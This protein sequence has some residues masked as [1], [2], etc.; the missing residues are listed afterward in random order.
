LKITQVLG[1]CIKLG[2]SY[3]AIVTVE[4]EV[5]LW[6]SSS[7]FVGNFGRKFQRHDVEILNHRQVKSLSNVPI[8][9]IFIVILTDFVTLCCFVYDW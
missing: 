1:M 4:S 2:S 5:E 3:L 9:T 7:H 6:N 8:F